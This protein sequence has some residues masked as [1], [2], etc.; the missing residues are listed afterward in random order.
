MVNTLIEAYK[1]YRKDSPGDSSRCLT[2]I[3]QHFIDDGGNFRRAAKYQSDLAKLY[4]EEG[5]GAN[6]RP[7]YAL[8]AQ[9]YEDDNANMTAIGLN[10]KSAE[11]AALDG[12]Y[13]DA[14]T[15][16]EHAAD[17]C[18]LKEAM[19]YSI[20]KYLLQAGYCHLALDIVGAMRALPGYQNMTSSLSFSAGEIAWLGGLMET[21][22]RGDNQAFEAKQVEWF[23]YHSTTKLQ[24]RK[25][26]KHTMLQWEQ[27]VLTR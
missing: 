25:N 5:D 18:L 20:P 7:A 16:F 22:E 14:I 12:D 17:Q 21:V 26:V 1:V 13:L 15:R 6:A 19:K 24:D 2:Q 8:A 3:V 9:W 4:D 11:Y 23:G 10:I 27:T